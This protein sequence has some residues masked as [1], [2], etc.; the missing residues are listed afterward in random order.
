MKTRVLIIIMIVIISTYPVTAVFAS[1]GGST[2]Q[3]Q[4]DSADSVF[5]GSVV[6]KQTIA[7]N[8]HQTIVVFSIIESFKGINSDQIDVKIPESLEDEFEY[9]SE[10]VIFAHG[11]EQPLGTQLCTFSFFAFPTVLNI[12][13]QLSNMNNPY[14]EISEYDIYDHL[15]EP[16]KIQLEDISTSFAQER[17]KERDRIYGQMLL[18]GAPTA[19]GIGVAVMW[20]I[21]LKSK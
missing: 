20:V 15:T 11:L 4:Y 16:E 12:V 2:L 7:D 1:C 9:G 17:Q 6:Q 10:Y 5:H 8:P 18:I 19:I 21:K 14:S 3:F 13:S